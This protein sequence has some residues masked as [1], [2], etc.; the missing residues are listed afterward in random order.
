MIRI[1]GLQ[2]AA[3]LGSGRRKTSGDPREVKARASRNPV[4]LL[5]SQALDGLQAVAKH[6]TIWCHEQES[7]RIK[8]C[9]LESAG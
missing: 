2:T 3:S 7:S 9:D 8:R 5:D 4:K 1:G 6:V